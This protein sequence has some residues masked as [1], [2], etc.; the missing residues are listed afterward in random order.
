MNDLRGQTIGLAG[1]MQSAILVDRFAKDHEYLTEYATGLIH[2]IFE[3]DPD[4]LEAVYGNYANI[5]MGLHAL[6][7]QEKLSREVMTYFNAVLV[8]QKRLRQNEALLNIMSSGIENIKGR[9][10]HFPMMHENI[11]MALADLYS[12]TVS[13][14]NPRIYV[15][16]TDQSFLMSERNAAMIRTLLLSGVRSG[17]LWHQYGGTTFKRLFGYHKV[18]NEARQILVEITQ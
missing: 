14:L 9:L 7:S 2:S 3:T 15:K 17:I 11:Q 1:A 13:K 8:L 18:A 5:A 6:A 12:Q 4:G 16:G 10:V